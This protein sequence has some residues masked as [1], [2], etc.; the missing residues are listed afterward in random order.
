MKRDIYQEITDTI[1]EQIE[2]GTA[3][4][5]RP[6]K[7]GKGSATMPHNAHTGR[8]YSGMNVMLLWGQPYASNGW[9]TYKQAIALGG[10]VIKGEKGNHIIF[11]KMNKKTDKT[12]GEDKFFPMLKT[13]C[14]FNVEQ[15]ENLND[16]VYDAPDDY[17]LPEMTTAQEVAIANNVKLNHGGSK[18]FYAPSR[19]SIQMPF[20]QDFEGVNG[21]DA[22][23]CHEMGHWTGNKSRLDRQFGKRFGDEAYAFEELVA[24]I[25]SAFMCCHLNIEL[26]GLQHASYV[27]NWLK[28]LKSD[29]RAIF[30]ASSQARQATEFLMAPYA[31][32]LDEAA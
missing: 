15:C 16:K 29:K 6:W 14:V 17:A 13:Y 25:T 27:E 24:E 19:D 3:P 2:Q 1:I 4:W 10:N 11:F 28:V 26:T 23:L 12:S 7:D 8:A 22:T 31:E 21:Y 9:L 32:Q 20:V 30:T 18:A 5:L